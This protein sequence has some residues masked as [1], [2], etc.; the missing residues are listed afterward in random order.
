M[1]GNAA[2]QSIPL[3]FGK[4]NGGTIHIANN[5]NGTLFVQ[6]NKRG[7]PAIGEEKQEDA[8]I[9]TVVTYTDE[10]GNVISPN[11]IKQGSNFSML[12]SVSGVGVTET[13][14]QLA[15]STYVPSG[16]EIHNARMDGT[17]STQHNSTFDYQDIRDDKVLTFF[18]LSQG[19]TKHYKFDLNATYAGTYYLPGIS[20]EAMY[21]KAYYSRKKGEWVKVY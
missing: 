17:E 8:G 12:V 21:D 10:K 16:W 5:G 11:A 4:N 20:L 18:S 3:P 9:K 6:L 7:K 2:I 15:L 1:H 14:H 13:L 19:E